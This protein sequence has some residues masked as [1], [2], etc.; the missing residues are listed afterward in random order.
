M[1]TEPNFSQLVY[2]YKITDFFQ[3]FW[4][5]N[6]LYINRNNYSFY[7]NILDNNDIDNFLQNQKLQAECD[8]F[9]LVKDGNSLDFKNWSKQESKSHQYIVNN[10]KL[11]EF[12]H[13]GF[14]LVINGV[15]KSIPKLIKFCN[16]LESELKFRIRANIYITPPTAQ[17]LLPHYDE[18]DVCILQIHGTKI[19][20]LYH[21]PIQL[22]SQQKDQRIGLHSLEKPE[23]E[24]ELKPG[25]LLYIPRG[26]IHQAFTTDTNS[27]HIALGLYPT[28]WFELLQDLVELAK[29][30]PAFR[31]AIPNE[32]M[33]DD[34]KS[35]F[36]EK[37]RQICQDLVTN[38]DVDTL[39]E[40]K[41]HQ[42]I[43]NK[44]SQD[45]SRFKDW[46]LIN[47]IN[48]NSILS[49]RKG[50]LFSIDKDKSNIHINF[51]N[52]SLTFPIFFAPS[53]ST[54]LYSDRFAVKDIG[55]LINNKGKIKLVTKFIQEG[56]LKIESINADD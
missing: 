7:N 10:K 25:D 38:L 42:F 21:S 33:N 13:Q 12:L 54:I 28:Y 27:I 15:H 24:V 32:F 37:F 56:F 46:L 4:E 40:T 43:V 14:T 35:F 22:P 2:P 5:K 8:N 9:F 34:Q 50:I 17:G 45:E 47:Q 52:K 41:S 29:E 44:R 19:W 16:L 55:G 20:H 1:N 49:R 26:L 30:N 48:L 11:F 23:F 53:L 51:Y 36:K 31:R 39:L 6:Y 18:H 3:S